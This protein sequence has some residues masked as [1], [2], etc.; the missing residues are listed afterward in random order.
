MPQF[1]SLCNDKFYIKPIFSSHDLTSASITPLGLPRDGGA[2]G[3]SR[4][5]WG[6]MGGDTSRRAIEN[7]GA[8]QWGRVLKA[9]CIDESDNGTT[10][11]GPARHGRGQQ[12]H[13]TEDNCSWAATKGQW[14]RG[15]SAGGYVEWLWFGSGEESFPTGYKQ[16]AGVKLGFIRSL[17]AIWGVKVIML[18][19]VRCSNWK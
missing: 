7:R 10:S 19:L 3:I 4:V 14:L 13:V 17:R 12:G 6:M 5:G 9:R 1:K 11:S 2:R 15:R 16:Q 8:S 18:F